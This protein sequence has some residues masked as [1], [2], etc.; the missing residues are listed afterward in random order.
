MSNFV[1]KPAGAKQGLPTDFFK[2]VELSTKA[3]TKLASVVSVLSK[4]YKVVITAFD[5]AKGELIILIQWADK[6]IK[7]RTVRFHKDDWWLV[8]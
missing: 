5:R 2:E 7:N 3:R 6:S 8:V 4:A 1:T